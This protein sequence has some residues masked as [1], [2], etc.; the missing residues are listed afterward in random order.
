M[1]NGRSE[2]EHG[3]MKITKAPH[4]I[5]LAL[6]FTALVVVIVFL[7]P[8]A[9]LSVR[10]IAGDVVYDGANSV[11]TELYVYNATYPLTEPKGV[12]FSLVV[13]YNSFC[14]I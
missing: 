9:R 10:P 13:A 5:T 1:S 12:F 4:R 14:F 3:L 7:I 8:R 2:V 11:E 6:L